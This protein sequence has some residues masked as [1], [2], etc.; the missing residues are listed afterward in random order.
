MKLL[1]VLKSSSLLSSYVGKI[2]TTLNFSRSCTD[3]LSDWLWAPLLYLSGM[4]FGVAPRADIKR[5]CSENIGSC[6]QNII[7]ILD[8]MVNIFG[9][10]HMTV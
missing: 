2:W 7:T 1:K 6:A 8:M 5:T 4:W 3:L 10:T 9:G